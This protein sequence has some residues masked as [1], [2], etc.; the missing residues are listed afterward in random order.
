MIEVSKLHYNG[1]IFI[2]YF[3]LSSHLVIGCEI[4]GLQ[5]DIV[6]E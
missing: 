6:A 3:V 4:A 2:K 1:T 5:N